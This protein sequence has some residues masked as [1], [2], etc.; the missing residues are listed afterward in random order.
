MNNLLLL[1]AAYI[2]AVKSAITEAEINSLLMV[3]F[4]VDQG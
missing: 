2:D 3:V 1:D 4:Q